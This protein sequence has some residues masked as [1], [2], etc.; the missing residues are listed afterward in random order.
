M[1]IDASGVPSAYLDGVYLGSFSGT[2]AVT[3][4]TRTDLGGNDPTG[5]NPRYFAG[6]VDEVRIYNYPRSQAQIL[7]DMNGGHAVGGSPVGS[8]VGYWKFDEGSS[9]SANDISVNSNTLTLSTATSAWTN[10]G[11]FNKAWDG[12]G[13][14]YVSR[15]DDSDFDVS[16]TDDYSISM[17]F[18]S[19][20]ASN[21]A[22]TE[23]IINKASATAPGY[24]I[25][26]NT[27]GQICFAIDDDATWSP[28]IASCTTNDYYDGNWHHVVGMR[29]YTTN[30]KTYIYIDGQIMDS[31][32]DSTEP[33]HWRP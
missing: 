21:P 24:A 18:K 27:S 31:D 11:K 12:N 19:D 7:E 14:R 8:Q 5:S 9:T 30:D 4:T 15:S 17:W 28:D 6:K 1:N 25:Y 32:S 33:I 10:S 26:A 23:Y 13:S 16:A 2:G 20:S 22:A 3:P 29:D